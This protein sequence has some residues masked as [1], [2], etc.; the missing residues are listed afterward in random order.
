MT[1]GRFL[2]L[3][4]FLLPAG[5]VARSNVSSVA[6]PSD[7]ADHRAP[8]TQPILYHRTGGFA[9]TD[10]R[11]VIWPDGL[12]EVDGRVLP[13]GTTRVSGEQLARLTSMFQGW[14]ALNDA[15]TD[16]SMADA[17][18]ITIHFGSKS[19]TASDTARGLPPRFRQ[20]FT[21]IESIAAQA[22]NTVPPQP[23]P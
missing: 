17:Y 10:D 23:A 15:Y 13:D 11:V 21:E 18:T 14:N 4:A 6:Q 19:V 2:I 8:G 12:V 22:S 1:P 16:S 9:G 7:L 5:C 3:L 20:I